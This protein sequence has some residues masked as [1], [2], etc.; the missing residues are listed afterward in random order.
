MDQRERLNDFEEG[1]RV[2]IEAA[3]RRMWTA[4]PAKIVSFDA[5]KGTASA[6]IMIKAIWRDEKGVVSPVDMPVL[7]DCPV[8]RFGGGDFVITAP[9]SVGDE[10]LVV[11]SSRAID[12]WWQSGQASL[13]VEYRMHDLSDGFIIP[14]F[15][16]VPNAVTGWST[17]AL[18]IR[19]KSEPDVYVEVAANGKITV[20]TY[21]TVF[22][23][24]QQLIING[25]VTVSGDLTAGFGGAGAVGLRTHVHSQGHDSHGDA[26]V[27]TNPPTAGT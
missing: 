27:P 11:F 3:Q 2:A 15:Q 13:P 17:D 14:G 12:A 4:M 5:T 6:Q 10:C 25:D 8:Q 1:I 24:C 23:N 19:S 26:E 9:I 21:G 18:Q 22:M 7:L 16:S 20:N